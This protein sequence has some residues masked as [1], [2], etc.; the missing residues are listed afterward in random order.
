MRILFFA[1][2]KNQYN[3]FQNL[4]NHLPYHSKVQFFPS[5]NLSFQG[6][7]LLKNIDQKAILESKYREMDAKYS[8]KLHKYLYKKL[9][10]FQLPWVL[11]V[12]F[13]PLSRYN[14]DYIILWNGKKFYQ[15]IVLEVAKLLEVKPIFFENGVLPN[16]TTMDFVGVNASNSL[17]REANFY[18]NLEYKDSSLPQSLEIRVSKKEKKQFN[19]KLP[20][21]YI[22]IPFQV[23]YDTQII[24]HSPWIRDMFEFF[25]IIEWLS[26]QLDI[27]FVIKEHPSDR[28]SNYTLLY[29]KATN[30][31]QFSSQNTQTLIEN[32]TAI[33]TINSSVAMESLLFKKRVIVLGEAFFAIDGIVKIAHS[34]EQIL[35]IL[36]N[37]NKWS[38][39]EPLIND[40]LHYLYEDYLIPTNWRNPDTKHYKAIKQK[41][42][43]RRC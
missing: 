36:E 14:P 38:I 26:Q 31:I 21:E 27:V 12:A 23:A 6:L 3:Y 2:T 25:E 34:K 17:P 15:E 30:H 40:F 37:L 39:D 41:I 4:A 28:V 10:Q 20:K 42:E 24:Q 13:K 35:D 5:L 11:M 22:F 7:K 18:Q 16:S 29:Q 1:V 8:S 43:E 33:M 32:A 19:T 9:L